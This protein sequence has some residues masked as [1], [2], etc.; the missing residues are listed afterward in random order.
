MIRHISEVILFSLDIGSVWI[1][2]HHEHY[3]NNL[4]NSNF[5]LKVDNFEKSK[6]LN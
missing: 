5:Y 3:D 4:K 1:I 6:T 2:M